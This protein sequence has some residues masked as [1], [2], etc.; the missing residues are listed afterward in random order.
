[1]AK[2]AKP[3]EVVRSQKTVVEGFS[4]TACF[5]EKCRDSGVEM[6]ILSEVYSILH[7]GKDPAR[8]IADLMGRDLKAESANE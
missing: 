6:P 4:A 2:G 8:A 3:D 5:F 1:L 7:K